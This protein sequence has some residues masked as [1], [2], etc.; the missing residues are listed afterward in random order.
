MV[1]PTIMTL[2]DD[3]LAPCRPP[4]AT[5]PRSRAHPLR[6][7]AGRE[8][9]AAAPGILAATLLGLGRALARLS[10]CSWSSDARTT[11][12][13]EPAFATAADR[14]GQTLTSKLGGSETHIAFGASLH[15]AAMVARA[16]L[17]SSS[18]RDLS[19]PG[20]RSGAAKPVRA[21]RLADRLFAALVFACAAVA[22][23]VLLAIFAAIALRGLPAVSWSFLTEPIRLVGAAGGV[24]YNV[25][26]TLILIATALLVALPPAVGLSLSPRP[27][28]LPARDGL[29]R[30]LAHALPLRSEWHAFDHLSAS[31]ASLIVFVNFLGWGNPAQGGISSDS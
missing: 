29:L 20:W 16:A 5:R 13:R 24:F 21:R 1:L 19:E 18:P 6:I 9:A 3:A 12:A 17:S 15:G 31:S 25:V 2:S 22:G 23:T 14:G 10:L 11:V 28:R 8:P 4:S 26:G 7:R 27:R 30:P